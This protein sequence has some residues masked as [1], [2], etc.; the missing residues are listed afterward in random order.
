MTNFYRENRDLRFHMSQAD[1][2]R[3]GPLLELEFPGDDPEAPVEEEPLARNVQ[4][5]QI[6]AAKF[7]YRLVR[8]ELAFDDYRTVLA[9]CRID[10]GPVHIV[11]YTLL[12]PV[13]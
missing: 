10:A 2:S 6:E 9:R 13:S 7:N 4:P 12:P 1:W 5:L 8:A 3:L 11:P